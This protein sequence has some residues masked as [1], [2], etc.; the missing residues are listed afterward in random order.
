MAR[1]LWVDKCILCAILHLTS[2][3]YRVTIG[4]Y[5]TQLFPLI[6]LAKFVRKQWH[7]GG[8]DGFRV[9]WKPAISYSIIIIIAG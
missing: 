3:Q 6:Y 4:Q 2:V 9:F 5:D 1:C 7:L 8:G